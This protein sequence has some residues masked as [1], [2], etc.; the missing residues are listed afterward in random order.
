M[1]TT[2][3]ETWSVWVRERGGLWQEVSEGLTAREAQRMAERIERTES[4]LKVR[5]RPAGVH[6][7]TQAG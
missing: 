5:V 7:T 2:T 3:C 4:S 6:P 1:K